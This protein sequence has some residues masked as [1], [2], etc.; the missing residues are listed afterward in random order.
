MTVGS[1]GDRWL[2]VDALFQAAL[3]R[4]PG[5]REDFL[6]EACGDDV[7]LREAVE[8]L[9]RAASDSREFLSRPIDALAPVS[10]DDVLAR[11]PGGMAGV[12][13][14]DDDADRSGERVGPYRLLHEIGRGGMAT[15]YLADRADGLWNQRVALK[16]VRRGL[17]T[18]DVIRRFSHER[19]ILSSLNHPNIGRLLDGGTTEDGL[20]YL[21]ME[22]VQGTPITEYCDGQR[23]SVAERLRLFCYVG[24]AVQHAHR[25]LVVHRDLKPS[26]I[27]VTAEGRVKLLDFGIARILDP[28]EDGVETRTGFR[29]LTPEYASPEQLSGETI[30]TASDVYQLGVLL[31]ELLSGSRPYSVR[32]L[33]SPSRLATYLGTV[34]PSLPSALVT[35]E[36]AER[37][38]R[39]P[40][41]LVQELKGDL[42]T[43]VREALPKEPGRRYPSAEA[44]V[45]DLERHLAGRPIRARPPTLVYR[46]GKLFRRRP[47]LLPAVAAVIVVL[48]GYAFTMVRHSRQLETERNLAHREAQRA[49]EVQRLLVDV[50]RSVDPYERY[51]GDGEPSPD[52]TVREA[53]VMGAERVRA[54]LHHRPYLKASLLGAIGDVYANLDLVT[55]A[56]EL[57][58]EALA[59]EEEIHG[60]RSPQVA[61]SLRKLG[62][63][64][65]REGSPDSAE[66]LLTRSLERT[67]EIHGPG[68]TAV[69]GVLTD[70]GELAIQR[71]RP[72]LAEDRLLSALELLRDQRPLPAARLAAANAALLDIYPGQGRMREARAVAEEAVRLHRLAYGD[73]D[74]RTALA[75]VE[76]ADLYDWEGRGEDAVP[77][78]RKALAILDRTLG[79]DHGYT[80][81]A[82]NNLAVTLGHL[83]DLEGAEAAHRRILEALEA[84]PGDRVRSR[85]DAHQ[86]LAVVLQDRGAL[87]EAEAQVRE[88]RDL[89]DAALERDHYQRAFPRLTLASLL[90]EKGDHTAAEQAAR[91]AVD[92]LEGSMGESSYVTATARCRVGR[93]LAGQGSSTQARRLLEPAVA[94][95]ARSS[96]PSVRYELECRR[97]LQDLYGELGEEE[98]ERAQQKAIEALRGGTGTSAPAG[99][100]APEEP[101]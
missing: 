71:G 68:D 52:L 66:V 95:L 89:Y 47:W 97:A 59:I 26:N 17:D 8:R 76:R 38:G 12:G 44:L 58:E 41:R 86:N 3:D 62:N 11:V 50:F 5:E 48:S 96:Q 36:A 83:G 16:L 80:L 91:E 24:E 29:P 32:R 73:E 92:I 2:E 98:L 40:G 64:L 7:E 39:D 65:A 45:A 57:R 31:C 93:A 67:R 78:Y 88:A 21:V 84:L 1:G 13:R 74:P 6:N 82:R 69:A 22:Y 77:V 56:R 33:L 60:P 28:A 90:M 61:R 75:L 100:G 43:I 37:R 35:P 85:A 23:L 4:E 63:L 94:I 25:S 51:D 19:Q 49:E 54:E 46:T 15:V 27:L 34:E 30:T 14:R 53:L 70:L 72:D 55:S 18:D 99:E 42:D 101:R 9:L 81:T 10:W 20:P 87:V 79:P